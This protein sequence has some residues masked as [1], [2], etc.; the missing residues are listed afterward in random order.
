MEFIFINAQY[1]KKSN[2]VLISYMIIY[3]F[4]VLCY[5]YPASASDNIC[6]D[7]KKIH[8]S[9]FSMTINKRTNNSSGLTDAQ[10]ALIGDDNVEL[11]VR[12][13]RATSSQLFDETINKLNCIARVTVNGTQFYYGILSNLLP[14]ETLGR[15][16]EYFYLFQKKWALR[17]AGLPESGVVLDGTVDINV[18]HK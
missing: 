15:R 14:M 4:C 5:S 17:E 18:T 12:L 6:N 8:I 3:A 13:D 2:A 16:S 11:F 10:K 1:I 9:Y 7:D